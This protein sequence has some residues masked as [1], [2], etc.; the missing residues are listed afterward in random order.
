MKYIVTSAFATQAESINFANSC[1]GVRI[2]V[3]A[4]FGGQ[5]N[6]EEKFVTAGGCQRTKGDAARKGNLALIA[7][8]FFNARYARVC[9]F[10]RGQNV[11]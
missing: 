3:A 7:L 5:A 6:P 2:S 10:Y 4:Q 1:A 8:T 9:C 11:G